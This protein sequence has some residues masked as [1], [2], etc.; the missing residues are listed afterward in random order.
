M[1]DGIWVTN[2]LQA[3]GRVFES[4]RGRCVNQGS[5]PWFIIIIIGAVKPRFFY[6]FFRDQKEVL[7][8]ETGILI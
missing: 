1:K 2:P 5:V 8:T 6:D 4:P 3:V 7:L